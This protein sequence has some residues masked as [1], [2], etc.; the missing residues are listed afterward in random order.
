[1]GIQ[2]GKKR[3]KRVKGTELGDEYGERFDYTNFE[4]VLKISSK[5]IFINVLHLW[6]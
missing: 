5:V 2:E 6:N 1:M 4:E 3:K